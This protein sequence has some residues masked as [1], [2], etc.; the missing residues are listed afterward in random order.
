MRLRISRYILLLLSLAAPCLADAQTA[1]TAKVVRQKIRGVQYE[2]ARK[3]VRKMPVFAGF[4]VSANLAGA[5]LATA[6]SYGELEGAVRA[7]IRGRYFPV[8]EGGLGLSDHTDDGTNLH[9]KTSSPFFRIGMDYNVLADPSSPNRLLAGA[10]LAYS[11]FDYD[12]S[13]PDLHDPYWGTTI[14][15]N[16]KGVKGKQMWLE[17]VMGVE[18]RI[19]KFFHLGWS[20]RYKNRITS[21]SGDVGDPWYVPGYGKKGS[22]VIG[23]TFSVIFDI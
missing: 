11:S 3:E 22:S 18:T 7:N 8:I 14:P 1:D 23:G 10:R 13:G 6:T 21:T 9:Y 19:W 2:A 12:I 5:F 16:F 4:S 17:L 15:Y 20:V